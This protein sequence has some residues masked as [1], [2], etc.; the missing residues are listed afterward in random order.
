MLK[1]FFL[2]LLPIVAL[3]ACSLSSTMLVTPA[4]KEIAATGGT[5]TLSLITTEE[6][7][8]WTAEVD[9]AWV[10]LSPTSGY[11]DGKIVVTVGRNPHTVVRSV[12]VCIRGASSEVFAYVLQEAATQEEN[13]NGGGD[14]GRGVLAKPEE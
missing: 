3:E 7:P 1:R 2:L 14:G 12:A 4:T 11:G 6:D 13:R 8:H 9:S 5:Y 10:T